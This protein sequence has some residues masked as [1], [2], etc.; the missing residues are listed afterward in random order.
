MRRLGHERLRPGFLLGLLFGHGLRQGGIDLS[1]DIALFLIGEVMLQGLDE[2]ATTR[3][4]PPASGALGGLEQSLRER[5]RSLDGP[6][7]RHACS[8]P[9]Y[10]NGSRRWPTRPPTS[11]VPE[12]AGG[13]LAVAA[14]NAQQTVFVPSGTIIEVRL[15]PLGGARSI[16]PASS[17]PDALPWASPRPALRQARVA[18]F[19]AVGLA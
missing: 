1:G 3:H 16:L 9:V 19:R 8:I 12:P 10:Q 11:A 14:A 17:D 13:R 18:T 7:A 5:N 4:T 6:V 2:D 15:E